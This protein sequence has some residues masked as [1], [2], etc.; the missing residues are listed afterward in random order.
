MLVLEMLL[1][2]N[3]NTTKKTNTRPRLA[4]PRILS[5]CYAIS[6]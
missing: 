5:Y 4:T 1:E 6:V 2:K 3:N